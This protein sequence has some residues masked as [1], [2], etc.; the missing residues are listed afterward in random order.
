MRFRIEP[1]IIDGDVEK[2]GLYNG[3]NTEESYSEPLSADSFRGALDALELEPE[4]ELF[5]ARDIGR[6]TIPKTTT[7]S[8]EEARKID[9]SL[10]TTDPELSAEMV[11]D[12]FKEKAE[13][14]MSRLDDLF[15]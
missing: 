14:M 5:S 3:T 11:N 9:D 15:R 6:A 8:R 12:E 4:E 1:R 7:L 13:S 10:F 2:N